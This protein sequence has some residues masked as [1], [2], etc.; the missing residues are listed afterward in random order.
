MNVPHRYE[1]V[2]LYS[3]LTPDDDVIRAAHSCCF[4]LLVLLYLCY[5]DKQGT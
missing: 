5:L 2:M 4:T 1:K 3:Y